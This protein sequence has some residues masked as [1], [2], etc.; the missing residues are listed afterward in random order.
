MVS[1]AG[2]KVNNS[3]ANVIKVVEHASITPIGQ[4]CLCTMFYLSLPSEAV[5]LGIGLK[6]TNTGQTLN[7]EDVTNGHVARR[8]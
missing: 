7:M 8:A 3:D 2:T 1:L 6:A 5:L 4:P